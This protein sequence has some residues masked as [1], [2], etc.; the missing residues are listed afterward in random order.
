MNGT[1]KLLTG[2][3]ALLFSA[4]PGLGDQ[5]PPTDDDIPEEPTWSQDVKPI[6]DRTC[7]ECHSVPPQQAAPGTLRLDVCET[8]GGIPGAKVMATRIIARV[9]D[10]V[11]SQMPPQTYAEQPTATDVEILQRWVDS[12]APCDGS[13]NPNA[14]PNNMMSDMGTGGGDM[15]G[16]SM[17]MGVDAAVDMGVDAGMYTTQFLAVVDVINGST[18]SNCHAASVPAFV[19]PEQ[20]TPEDIMMALMGDA[21]S[22]MMPYVNPPNPDQSALYLR[23]TAD[24]DDPYTLMPQGGM[25][26]PATDL[27]VIEAWI[28]DGA[29]FTPN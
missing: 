24:V 14:M 11:P 18:C 19:I 5:Q 23:L 1:T 8:V 29:M 2:L 9:V 10:K 20:A 16:G 3:T 12:G 28:Q 13:V 26:L 15:G 21:N 4:C 27:Q 25:M 7:N 6:L 17:D 22:P